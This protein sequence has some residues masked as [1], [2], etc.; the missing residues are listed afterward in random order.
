MADEQEAIRDVMRIL[1]SRKSER[2]REA[3][4]KSQPL[5]TAAAAR[6]W[7]PERR[8]RH[9]EAQQ[10]RR[11]RERAEREQAA[12]GGAGQSSPIGDASVQ[13]GGAGR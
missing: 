10:R 7:T 3:L 5:A 9:S 4:R 11:E 2:K 8:R 6:S 12:A 13:V 1:G